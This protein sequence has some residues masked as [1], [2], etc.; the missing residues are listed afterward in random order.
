[1]SNKLKMICATLVIT[2]M[3]MGSVC[4][5][6][7]AEKTSEEYR[8]IWV[9]PEKKDDKKMEQKTMSSEEE[10]RELSLAEILEMSKNQERC[11]QIKGKE[12]SVKII[13]S[14][15]QK[16]GDCHLVT[17]KD[18]MLKK[19]EFKIAKDH[20]KKVENVNKGDELVLQGVLKEISAK[21]VVL[22][23]TKVVK[24]TEKSKV[25][26]KNTKDIKENPDKNKDQKDKMKTNEIK[27]DND[28]K[29]ENNIKKDEQKDPKNDCDMKKEE[30]KE[31]KKD[32]DMKK[33]EKKEHKKDCDMK[34]EEKKEHKKDCD[35][36]KDQIKETKPATE[37]KKMEDNKTE[38]KE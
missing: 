20:C 34:K 27:K 35:I 30:K 12:I 26:Q 22:E 5:A 16:T 15:V 24:V 17:A 4:M 25:E 9:E 7:T 23:E 29:K 32:C 8:T 36:K 10:A 21:K 11:N 1:M 6:K 14:K 33:E 13:V 2:L 19:G 28:T 37:N 18:G 38:D 31:H 3:P